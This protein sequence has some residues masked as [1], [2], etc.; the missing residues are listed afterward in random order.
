[1]IRCDERSVPCHQTARALAAQWGQSCTRRRLRPDLRWGPGRHRLHLLAHGPG[2]PLE[3]RSDRAT[4]AD[5]HLP[6]GRRSRRAL[7]PSYGVLLPAT[8]GDR[9]RGHPGHRAVGRRRMGADPLGR[10]VCRRRATRAAAVWNAAAELRR[11]AARARPRIKAAAAD[12]DGR[13]RRRLLRVALG[14]NQAASFRRGGSRRAGAGRQR[15]SMV[16]GP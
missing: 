12:E 10:I 11:C 7:G 2:L 13:V 9:R 3:R 1:M 16:G 15:S 5:N 6:T 4:A 14:R 8:G